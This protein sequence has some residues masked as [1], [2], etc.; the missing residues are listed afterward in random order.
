MTNIIYST[1]N[2]YYQHEFNE[3]GNMQPGD[4]RKKNLVIMKQIIYK[5]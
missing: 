2:K 5:K 1:K 4:Y 3:W